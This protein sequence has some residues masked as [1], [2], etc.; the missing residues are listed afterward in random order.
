MLREAIQPL[1]LSFA[2]QTPPVDAAK[3]GRWRIERE[4]LSSL[5]LG[6]STTSLEATIAEVNGCF[7]LSGDC[8]SVSLAEP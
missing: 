7:G 8:Y 4:L 2:E 6:V 1:E 5:R 3:F